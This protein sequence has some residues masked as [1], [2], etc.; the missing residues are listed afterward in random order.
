MAFTPAGTLIPVNMLTA[1]DPDGKAK[2]VY[3]FPE[4]S[5]ATSLNV[6]VLPDPLPNR[7][8]NG[9]PA[10]IL[11]KV[12]VGENAVATPADPAIEAAW[13]TEIVWLEVMF[14]REVADRSKELAP[15]REFPLR[16]VDNP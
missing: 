1:A 10:S 4:V 3:A 13:A 12:I 15:R 5:V 11:V 16:R 6:T 14:P 8:E 7:N 9:V 2:M